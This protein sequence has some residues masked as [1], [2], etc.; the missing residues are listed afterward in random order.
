MHNRGRSKTAEAKEP[1]RRVKGIFARMMEG[2]ASEAAVPKA[3]MID[4]AYP[5][6]HSTAASLRP[7]KGGGDDPRGRLIGRTKRGM[8]TKLY[9]VTDTDGRPIRFFMA[10]GQVSDYT[11]AAVRLESLPKSRLAG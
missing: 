6:A 9:S 7:K 10:A 5:K 11:G 3:V 4:A 8:N 2:L 1:V